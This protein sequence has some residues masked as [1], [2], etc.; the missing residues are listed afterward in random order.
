MADTAICDICGKMRVLRVIESGQKLCTRCYKDFKP[1]R[2]ADLVT[3][4]TLDSYAAR[5]IQLPENL[6]KAQYHQLKEDLDALHY[7]L[8]NAWYTIVGK[9]FDSSGLSRTELE[10]ACWNL[11]QTRGLG[12][13]ILGLERWRQGIQTQNFQ[14]AKEQ[15]ESG[16]SPLTFENGEF[17]NPKTREVLTWWDFKPKLEPSTIGVLRNFLRKQFPDHIC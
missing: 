10:V 11:L 5:G 6:T 2:D 14:Q 15:A 1:P 8:M 16:R 3:Y 17:F 13:Q 12:Q 7:I 4:A 9:P